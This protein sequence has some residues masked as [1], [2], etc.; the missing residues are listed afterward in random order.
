MIKLHQ[1]MFVLFFVCFCLSPLTVQAQKKEPGK[2]STTVK[3]K[4]S[5]DENIKGRIESYLKRELRSLG[6][7]TVVDEKPSWEICLVALEQHDVEGEV[8]SVVLSVVILT[9]LP[10]DL[11][12]WVLKLNAEQVDYIS[13]IGCFHYRAHWLKTGPPKGLKDICEGIIA[14]FDSEHLESVREQYQKMSEIF[15]KTKEQEEKLKIPEG[16]VP[17]PNKPTPGFEPLK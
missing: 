17:T 1:V 2:F 5:A 3:V 7:V 9:P 16:F 8:T 14:D 11:L 13:R 12:G 6:D 10:A 4:V 15:K